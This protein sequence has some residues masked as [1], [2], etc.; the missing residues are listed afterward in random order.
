VASAFRICV[1][2][3]PSCL[4]PTEPEI[5]RV[6][7]ICL[8]AGAGAAPPPPRP[9]LTPLPPT[10][11]DRIR[12]AG[13]DAPT[14]APGIGGG[15]KA[16]AGFAAPGSLSPPCAAPVTTIASSARTGTRPAGNR[17]ETFSLPVM[18]LPTFF[19]AHLY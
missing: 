1:F 15:A 19:H 17:L 3:L 8:L 6:S 18:A 10:V 11:N 2:P 9:S 13:C 12:G 16:D 7:T 14:G 5:E 4:W